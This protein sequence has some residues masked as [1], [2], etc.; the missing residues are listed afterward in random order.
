ITVASAT[1]F[2]AG[3]Y[4]YLR[5]LNP[6]YVSIDG[7][8]GEPTW[9]S[10]NTPTKAMCQL[11]RVLSVRG[12]T[13]TLQRPYYLDMPNS[14][15]IGW[16]NLMEGGGVEN[17]T[18]ER[19]NGASGSDGWNINFD[20]VAHG[21]IMNVQSLNT[22]RSHFRLTLSYQSEVRGCLANSINSAFEHDGDHA[23]G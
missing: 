18:L 13:V 19:T 21:W 5:Q 4:V 1:R 6:A 15:E 8:N 16:V 10:R 12:N 7:D 14:P 9:I 17:L 3:T 22:G 20:S 11:N 23:Y 2:S